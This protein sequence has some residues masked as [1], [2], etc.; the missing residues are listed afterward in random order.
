MGV[1][2][3]YPHVEQF[4]LDYIDAPR[5]LLGVS[6]GADSV[7]LMAFVRALGDAHDIPPVTVIYIDHGLHPDSADWGVLVERVSRRLAFEFDGRTVTVIASGGGLEEA[8]RAARYRAFEDLM[9]EQ[10]VLMT[11]HHQDDQLETFLM[12]AFRGAG[13]EGLRS[14]LPER[15]LGAG[16]LIRPLLSV[17]RNDL[18]HIATAIAPDYV[19]DPSNLDTR[20]DRGFLRQELVPLI[21]ARWPQAA[22]SVGRSIELLQALWDRQCT[23]QVPNKRALTGEPILDVSLR[24]NSSA[25]A[26]LIRSWLA[27]LSLYRP[28]KAQLDEFVRQL[29]G[30]RNDQGPILQTGHYALRFY[31]GSI[32]CC[33]DTA[34]VGSRITTYE[35]GAELCAES[36]LGLFKVNLPAALKGRFSARTPLAGESCRTHSKQPSRKLTKLLHEWRVPPW[37]RSAVVVMCVDD[38]VVSVLNR[39]VD[40]DLLA[41]I[42][43]TIE[44]LK[45]DWQHQLIEKSPFVYQQVSQ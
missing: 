20:Y 16:L 33:S 5:W 26:D 19:H 17:A 11:A 9:C 10:D 25:L 45:V 27:E 43:P 12:R 21:R 41:Q 28:S 13:P 34:N 23:L 36:A 2:G 6:G 24:L 22:V 35:A 1:L 32:Y 42:H 14:M 38:Q 18:V 39:V 31:A 8:A 7:A 30:V 44:G 40:G 3:K 37:W 15:S 4:L 29:Q